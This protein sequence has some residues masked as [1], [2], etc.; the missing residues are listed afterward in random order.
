MKVLITGSEGFVGKNMAA[1][2]G[3][4]P[5]WTVVGWDWDPEAWPDVTPFDWCIHL[6]ASYS[7][8]I[9]T[10]M[11]QNLEFSQWLFDEC[12]HNGVNL[13]YA[14]T[15]SVYGDTKDFSEYSPCNPLT[16]YAQ[17]KLMFD[18][19]V[20]KQ[21][22]HIFV[23]G[24]RYFEL[25]GK[26]EHLK[27]GNANDLHRWREQA[28]KQGYIEVWDGAEDIY[29]DYTFVGDICSLHLD[30]INTVKGS[31]IWNAGS[32]LQHSMLSIAEE[33]AEQEGV[34]IRTIPRPST[35]IPR[36][37]ADLSHLKETVGKRKWLNVYEWL[38]L[39]A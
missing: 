5:D 8:D 21:P 4:Q 15:S 35:V 20:F 31:G 29:R 10:V 32:G 9:E 18:Q 33:I 27:G 14:S 23:Q 11:H 7:T 17:S 22:Q 16:P 3:R 34:E 38:D 13:Q 12:Q 19:W 26:W 28:R 24:F 37:R 25:Y 30:F 36:I 6:G 1:F 2:L 39:E